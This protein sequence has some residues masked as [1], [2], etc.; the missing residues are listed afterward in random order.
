MLRLLRR[1]LNH[2]RKEMAPHARVITALK[3]RWSFL[4]IVDR[5]HSSAVTEKTTTIH[6][7][8][9][10]GRFRLTVNSSP[11]AGVIPDA[12]VAYRGDR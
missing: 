8:G 2:P 1:S 5:P 3:G 12:R 9:C 10:T 6:L 4:M 11:T 7:E